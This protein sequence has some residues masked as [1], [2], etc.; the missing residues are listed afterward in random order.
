MVNDGLHSSNGSQKYDD[1]G[2]ANLFDATRSHYS[3]ARETAV[4]CV[5]CHKKTDRVA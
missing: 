4:G 1:T 5:Y 2:D 3:L